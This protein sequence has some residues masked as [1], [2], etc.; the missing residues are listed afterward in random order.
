MRSA[1]GPPLAAT[2]CSQYAASE[3]FRTRRADW[4]REY[5]KVYARRL[6]GTVSDTD[7]DEW[8]E[9]VRLTRAAT[10][11]DARYTPFDDWR[12]DVKGGDD[13]EEILASL[14]ASS[15]EKEESRG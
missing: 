11:D 6:R 14:R 2:T 15:Q 3:R 4:M 8:T 5:R 12:N 9:Y 7:W 13:Y 1:T 10:D